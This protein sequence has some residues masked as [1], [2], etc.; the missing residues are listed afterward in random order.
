M[1]LKKNTEKMNLIDCVGAVMDVVR[2]RC[3]MRDDCAVGCER[4]AVDLHFRSNYRRCDHH[5]LR[6]KPP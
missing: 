3:V 6:K 5:S 1:N 2:T 4:E